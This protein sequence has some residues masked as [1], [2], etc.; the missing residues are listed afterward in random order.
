LIRLWRDTHPD[1]AIGTSI[2]PSLGARGETAELTIYRVVQEALTNV[3]RHARATRVDITVEPAPPPCAGTG[4]SG[5]IMVSVRDNGAGLPADHKQG[6]GML[7]MRERV[8]ALGGTLTVAS[9]NQG[10]TVEA[11]VPSHPGWSAPPRAG[12]FPD[13]TT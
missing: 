11:M 9:T 3:F 12:I 2:S 1:V 4:D 8:L 6:L 7:G 13:K 10:V 5:A